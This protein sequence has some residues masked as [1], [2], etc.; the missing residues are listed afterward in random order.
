M[1]GPSTVQRARVRGGA[2]SHY[3]NRCLDASSSHGISAAGPAQPTHPGYPAV[4]RLST[5]S[6]KRF[7]TEV[8]SPGI[9]TTLLSLGSS[10]AITPPC[11]PIISI[12]IPSESETS[13]T[14]PSSTPGAKSVILTDKSSIFRVAG[15][16]WWTIIPCERS[17]RRASSLIA[18]ASIVERTGRRCNAT[19][20]GYRSAR[21]AD[22]AAIFAIRPAITQIH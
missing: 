14:T 9:Q 10:L 1:S 6:V 12:T 15:L 3:L 22:G 16:W 18:A 2:R 7:H 20:E 19:L 17:V 8:Q 5:V 21:S 13:P 11:K 4:A